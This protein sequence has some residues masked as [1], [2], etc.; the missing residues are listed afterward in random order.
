MVEYKGHTRGVIGIVQGNLQAGGTKIG[1][2]GRGGVLSCSKGHTIDSLFQVFSDFPSFSDVHVVVFARRNYNT[3]VV[4][5]GLNSVS[6]NAD[7][8][9]T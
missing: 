2:R 5:K 3:Y 4:V 1:G 7:S 9:K 8:A 6:K